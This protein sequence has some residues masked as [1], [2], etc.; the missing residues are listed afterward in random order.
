M[1]NK[2]FTL[3]EM[4]AV[5]ALLAIIGTITAV[6]V[7]NIKKNQDEENKLNIISAIMTGARNYITENNTPLSSNNIPT[8]DNYIYISDLR[9]G[10]YVDFDIEKYPEYYFK[11]EDAFNNYTITTSKTTTDVL[12]KKRNIRWTYGKVCNNKLK[13]EVIYDY[14][15]K[16][17]YKREVDMAKISDCGCLGQSERDNSFKLCDADHSNPL[18]ENDTT[19]G[20]DTNGIY[21]CTN[22]T[23]NPS[24]NLNED[25]EKGRSN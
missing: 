22:G 14:F 11:T 20:W 9:N 13:Y 6:S 21:R 12:Y 7:K 15:S 2:G 4:L 3:V 23:T 19:C 5:I 8:E 18:N 1:K 10:G 16:S 24:K 25:K 17:K